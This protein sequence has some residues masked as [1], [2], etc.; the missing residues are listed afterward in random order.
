MYACACR[1]GG[2]PFERCIET[3]PTLLLLPQY[4]LVKALRCSAIIGAVASFKLLACAHGAT[5]TQPY[6]CGLT[7]PSCKQ[8]RTAHARG[9]LLRI[10]VL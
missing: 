1:C 9:S 8:M 6:M 4:P 7:M 5:S 2:P 10:G 3:G